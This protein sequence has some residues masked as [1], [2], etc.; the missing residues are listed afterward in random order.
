M[1][2]AKP[3]GPDPILLVDS[4]GTVVDANEPARALFGSCVGRR[5]AEVVCV[6]A[7]GETVCNGGCTAA[8]I[9]A[10]EH[11]EIEGTVRTQR[12]RVRCTSLDGH[13][14]VQVLPHVGP[15]GWEEPLTPRELEV[16]ELVSGGLTNARIARRLGITVATVRTH[17]EHIRQKLGASTRAEAVARAMHVG[18]LGV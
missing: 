2:H 4:S 7:D 15:E 16:L 13:A 14:V 18:W 10:G 12:H 11:R 1:S 6:R 17:V 3:P 8:L 5:C 9:A